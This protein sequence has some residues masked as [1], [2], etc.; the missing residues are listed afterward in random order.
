MKRHRN[1]ILFVLL[2][3]IWGGA[4]PAIKYGLSFVPP[5]LFAAVRY[6]IASI[7]MLG[8]VVT[9][10]RYWR[11]RSCGDWL[12]VI[13]GGVFV[14]AAYNAFLFMGEVSVPSAV[15]GLLVGLMP[16]FSA[17]FS[18]LFTD[19][20]LDLFDITGVL[21]GFIGIVVIS[22]PDPS[23][24]LSSSVVG[25]LLVVAAAISMAFGSVLTQEIDARQ[26]VE[27]LEAW[28][29]VVGAVVLHTV[30]FVH[31]NET[32]GQAAWTTEAIVMVGYLAVLSSAVA[33]FIYFDLLERLGPFE[34]NFIAYAAAAFGALFGW[35]LLNEQ[36][37]VLTIT[38]FLAILAGFVLLKRD[39]ILQEISQHRIVR[40]HT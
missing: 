3:A 9:T 30:S 37:S 10:T 21:F 20:N 18:R 40:K 14:I 16:I 6:D 4:Y 7:L 32:I 35:L 39:M 34:M 31:P 27:T 17:M 11:P 28:S 13:L 23:N 29:M 25:Q 12:N 24:L 19:K 2:G 8:Y 1:L 26:P 38:G 22:R 33:Y 5:V 15:A 36:L